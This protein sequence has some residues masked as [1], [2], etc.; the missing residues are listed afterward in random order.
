MNPTS[1]DSHCL[2]PETMPVAVLQ[3]PTAQHFENAE[4]FE[5]E[6]TAQYWLLEAQ[7]SSSE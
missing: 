2:H 1:P 4:E 7:Q 6:L 3:P 5:K